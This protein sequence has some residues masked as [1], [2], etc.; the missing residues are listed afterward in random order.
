MI[1]DFIIG[2]IFNLL[3]PY[4]CIGFIF[5][6]IFGKYSNVKE[7][8]L[9]LYSDE[10]SNVLEENA[11]IINMNCFIEQN[12]SFINPSHNQK[13]KITF[14][15]Y[16]GTQKVLYVPMEDYSNMNVGQSGKLITQNNCFYEE[17]GTLISQNN[18]FLAFEN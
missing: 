13:Y 10:I 18:L 6:S 5:G 4:L 9:E 3:I 8:P 2:F 1:V 7:T 11:S 15:L 12:N 16:D 14:S 17:D